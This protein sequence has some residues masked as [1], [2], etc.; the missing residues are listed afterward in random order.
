MDGYQKHA[1]TKRIKRWIGRGVLGCI[2]AA[3]VAYYGSSFGL[4]NTIFGIIDI[5]LTFLAVVLIIKML[6]WAME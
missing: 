6:D 1:K 5:I 4:L 2:V 3:I